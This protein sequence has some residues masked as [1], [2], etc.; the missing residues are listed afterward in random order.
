MSKKSADKQGYIL[1]RSW[2]PVICSLSDADAGKLFKSIAKYQDGNIGDICNELGETY[3]SGIFEMMRITFVRDREEYDAK[4][5]MRREVGRAGGKASAQ[6]R[7]QEGKSFGGNQSDQLQPIACDNIQNKANQPELDLDI[8]SD[9]DVDSDIEK[10]AKKM[11]PLDHASLSDP[12]RE[13]HRELIGYK[14]EPQAQSQKSMAR[15]ILN[16]CIGAYPIS[17]ELQE[18][19][20]SWLKYKTERRESYKEQGLRALIKKASQAEK[21]FGTAAVI[22][23]IESSIANRYQGIT[24]DRIGSR[25]S[26]G[27]GRTA[28]KNQF[29]SFQQNSYDFDALEKELFEL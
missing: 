24:W 19:V 8:D 4:C 27:G 20:E 12:V 1:Y 25:T 18:T 14:K 26:P 22:D 17:K 28:K 2:T 7:S 10:D 9:L 6:K 21:E 29:N 23:V 5:A 16:A 11:G 15:V 3:L 13:A